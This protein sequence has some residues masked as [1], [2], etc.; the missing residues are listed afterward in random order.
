MADATL[1]SGRASAPGSARTDGAGAATAPGMGAAYPSYRPSGVAWLGDVPEHWIVSRLKYCVSNMYSGGTPES[2]NEEYWAWNDDDGIAWVA[3]G[4]M[5]RASIVTTTDK[6]ITASGL[7]SKR[8][9]V[10][11]TGTLL[12]SMYASLGKVATL[13]MP[14]T[15]NQA[16]LG[17]VPDVRR[18]DQGF[19]RYWLLNMERHL[20]QFSSSN[21][22]DNLNAAKVQS[23]P[24][25]VP[26]LP[27]QQAIAAWLD[28]RARRI[29]ELVASK[30]RLVGLLVEQRT[31]LITHAVT[32]GLN[33]AAPM[34]PS[35]I[36]WLG[37]LPR[38]WE[39]KRIKFIARVGNGSTPSRENAE[40]WG[41]EYPWL[42]SGVVN[43]REVTE[44][45]DF[46]TDLALAECHLPIVH[47]PAVLVG[48]TGEGKT[49]GMATVL[50]I[51]ATINQHLSFVKPTRAD[52]DTEYMRYVLHAAYQFLRD[53]SGGGGSTKGALTC[54]QLGNVSMPLPPHPE[55]RA[56]VV[57]LDAASAKLD[58]LI[59]ATETAIA[60]L[61]EYR[62]ALI[63]AAITGKINVCGV[64]S[65]AA[66]MAWPVAA[67]E[68][69]APITHHLPAR[70][71]QAHVVAG[72]ITS[73]PRGANKH[74]RRTVL[75]AQII[76]TIGD[77]L[78]FGR[79]KLQK[80]MILAEYHLRIDEIQS[81]PVRAAAGPFDN[82][83]MQ[84][85]HA[86]L[87]RSQWYAYDQA[88]HGAKY[89]ALAKAGGHAEYFDRYWSDRRAGF[90]ALMKM[91][92]PM[93]TEQ[94]E[95]VATLYA[96]WNDFIIDGVAA[97]DDA[98]VAEVSKN[99]HPEKAKITE[100]RW[101][102]ALPWMR[103]HG[104]VPTGY[105]VHTRPA[106]NARN[107][108]DGGDQV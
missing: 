81:E 31:T 40:Y 25:F 61:T 104:L 33:P 22:Q 16:I 106:A 54:E 71:A 102:K 95:I 15:I 100:D 4:D 75:A 65:A 70:A 58:A 53:E 101:R 41:G 21:T 50:R 2:G 28:D 42:N 57:H 89:C 63:S 87:K 12:Y 23:M 93:T 36:D 48:I 98:V 60:R 68:A 43:L 82:Q 107:A 97:S 96:A 78:T 62:Q 74:F 51:E 6:R 38:H 37:E 92:D 99:W 13:G 67:L 86:Q 35:G 49:R 52:C 11:P 79:V 94:A 80:A 20:D 27:E 108:V 7:A 88:R 105:G 85:V 18:T 3:I 47:P 76:A 17:I 90:D 5:T 72:R 14:A 91:F 26:P 19:L 59:A 30:Q 45:S 1:F 44:A 9:M 83:M 34:K 56:I 29:D 24:L 84:S 66:S 10:L 77:K 8:L 103:D 32:K 39:V 64:V 55:Q 69:P 73:Q 46:V